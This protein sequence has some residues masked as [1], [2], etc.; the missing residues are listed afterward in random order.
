MH[1]RSTFKPSRYSVTDAF[2]TDR[3]GTSE[4]VTVRVHDCVTALRCDGW[5]ITFCG[6]VQSVDAGGRIRRQ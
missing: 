2:E 6:A 5:D 4:D 1:A 3:H